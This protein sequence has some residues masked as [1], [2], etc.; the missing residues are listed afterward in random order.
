MV[1]GSIVLPAV[2]RKRTSMYPIPLMT[3]LPMVAPPSATTVSG[4]LAVA[5]IVRTRSAVAPTTLKLR[6]NAALK[7]VPGAGVVPVGGPRPEY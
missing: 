4:V 7:P 6:V 1:V 5:G 2:A 3:S